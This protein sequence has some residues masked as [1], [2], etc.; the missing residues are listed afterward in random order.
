MGTSVKSMSQMEFTVSQADLVKEL[1][2]SQG[3]VEKKTTIPILSNVLIEA[4]GQAIELTATDLEIGVRSTCPA[5]VTTEGSVTV[6]AKKLLD[7]VRLLE[8]GEVSVRLQENYWVQITA[9]RARTRIV[10]MS[11]ENFPVLPQP[12]EAVARLQSGM[13]LDMINKIIFAVSSEESRYTLNGALLVVRADAVTMV[14]TD[15]HRLALIESPYDSGVASEVRALVGKKALGELIRL[16]SVEDRQG[17]VS[18]GRDEN[19]LFFQVGAR[20][21]ISRLLSGQFPNY[22]AVVPRENN[23]VA[24]LDRDAVAAA[25]RRV[26][27]FA[28]ERSHA[29]RVALAP[30]EVKVS[31]SSSESGESEESLEA[32]YSGEPMQI[33][34]NCQYLLDFL[35][36]TGTGPVCFE[37]KDEQ[38]AGQLRPAATDGPQYRYVVMPM[39]I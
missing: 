18:F 15:G 10:G 9:K 13:L 30:G 17:L 39:R 37:F 14:A 1:G 34:F 5:K 26:S 6:P 2:L 35:A 19:H 12:P 7:Y 4:R 16:L 27:Q 3:V 29:V 36:A 21:V 11:R 28:D 25:L 33:G 38:S 32:D 22:E 23:R 20:M 31:S 24:V 8:G